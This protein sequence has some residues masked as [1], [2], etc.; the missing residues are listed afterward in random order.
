MSAPTDRQLSVDEAAT[1][2]GISPQQLQSLF[3]GVHGEPVRVP[4]G[5]L[6]VVESSLPVLKMAAIRMG[7]LSPEEGQ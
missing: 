6:L 7:Y 2:L 5:S 1:A 3:T 4:P